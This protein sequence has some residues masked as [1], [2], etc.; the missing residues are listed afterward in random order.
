MAAEHADAVL[1]L[2]EW[3]EFHTVDAERLLKNMKGNVFCGWTKSVRS[4]RDEKIGFR[5]GD[6]KI[7]RV[8]LFLF[9]KLCMRSSSNK[10]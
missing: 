4:A 9:E 8:E 1:L 2:T 6:G 7:T 10:C 5:Y 3:E